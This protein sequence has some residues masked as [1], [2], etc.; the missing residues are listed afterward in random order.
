L[1]GR[2]RSALTYLPVG[3]IGDPAMEDMDHS[4]SPSYRHISIDDRGRVVVVRFI[5][6]DRIL[7][8][9]GPSWPESYRDFHQLAHH[10][11]NCFFVLDFQDQTITADI[12]LKTEICITYLTRLW[13]EIKEAQGSLKLCNL[14]MP[15]F[16]AIRSIHLDRMFSIYESLD[17][18]LASV[19]VDAERLRQ[20]LT[21]GRNDE[22]V[23]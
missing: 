6:L 23:N 1:G 19:T 18:A 22:G 7:Q 21:E 16:E 2:D 13:K 3:R 9:K 17:D 14:P 15:L 4:I 8:I 5:D 11:R 20:A 10:H 12:Y